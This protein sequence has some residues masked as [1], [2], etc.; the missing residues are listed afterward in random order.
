LHI[1]A[2]AAALSIITGGGK[3]VNLTIAS[4]PLFVTAER[5]F[6]RCVATGERPRLFNAEPLRPRV[7]AVGSWT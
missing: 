2:A 3:W 1:G 6:W 4:D 7:D 5:N